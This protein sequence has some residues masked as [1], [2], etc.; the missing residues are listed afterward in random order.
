MHWR[1][2]RLPLLRHMKEKIASP[3]KFTQSL[4]NLSRH[5]E[6]VLLLSG[7]LQPHGMKKHLSAGAPSHGRVFHSQ[8]NPRTWFPTAALHHRKGNAAEVKT[9]LWGRRAPALVGPSWSTCA[10][11]ALHAREAETVGKAI[12]QPGGPWLLEK[13]RGFFSQA[14]PSANLIYICTYIFPTE[15]FRVYGQVSY[16][17]TYSWLD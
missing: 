10:P 14:L 3:Q 4:H 9:T 15:Q 11:A 6:L 13:H 17:G 1:E 12:Q 7:H 16:I 8:I 5:L 2:Q